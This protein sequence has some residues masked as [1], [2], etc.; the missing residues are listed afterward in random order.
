MAEVST[1]FG[2][3]S[4]QQWVVPTGVYLVTIE[5]W[6]SAGSREG[7]FGGYAKGDLSVSPG[8]VLHVYVGD[9][10]SNGGAAGYGRGGGASD[11]R[12]GGTALS[13]RVIVA[14]GGGGGGQATRA[15]G[16][17][18]Y[19][20]GT[21]GS[22]ASTYGGGGGGT[23]SA[24][25]AGGAGKTSGNNGDP[26]QLGTGGEWNGGYLSGEGAQGGG[27]GGGGYY[28]GGGGGSDLTYSPDR[29]GGGGGGS[30]YIGGV[31]NASTQTGV[32]S[33]TSGQAIITYDDNTAPDAPTRVAPVDGAVLDWQQPNVFDWQFNDPDPGDSQ[34]AYNW[35]YRLSGTTAW[36]E[37]GWVTSTSTQRT[38][39]GGTFTAGD[40]E[41]RVATKDAQGVESPW[42][43][44][45]FFTAADA[46]P[47]PTVTDPVNGGTIPTD[48]YP[49][50]WSTPDQD[51]YQL[52][53]LDGETVLF[54]TG[55][56]NQ[57]TARSRA[58]TFPDN[59]VTRSIRV[60]VLY[61]GLWSPW[62][63]VTVTVSYTPPAQP[64][65][66]ATPVDVGAGVLSAIR[67]DVEDPAPVGDEPSVVAHDVW[68][69]GGP[70][71]EIRLA[72]DLPASLPYL[73]HL[74]ASGVEYVFRARAVGDTGT[75]SWSEWTA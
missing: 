33:S 48:E 28:G 45:G 20:S 71:G 7:G 46:P 74:P 42:S 11:V 40:Y 4:D 25:G 14:G 9:P 37:T 67:V 16:H 24:G 35:A 58:V 47:G 29:G 1:T 18:G 3:G 49:V 31:T 57:P 41:W 60:R 32:H 21:A 38:V 23:Q 75:S 52:Q 17:G 56:V 8:E 36:T 10:W 2:V 15:G 73:W 70:E 6:G 12:H 65:V 61:G 26:G 13:N 54:D 64:L 66:T 27:G 72:A 43:S 62:S 30:S 19:P 59:N 68:V 22:G 55:Q 53:V 63:T 39:A 50:T 69:R 34:S 5:V 44:T 51:A